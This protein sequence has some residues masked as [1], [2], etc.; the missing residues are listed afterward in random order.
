M[1]ASNKPLLMGAT[2]PLLPPQVGTRP[3]TGFSLPMEAWLQGPLKDWHR[4]GL[5]AAFALGIRKEGAEAL[6]RARLKARAG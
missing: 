3:K 2:A 6:V 4:E 5:Q 1:L